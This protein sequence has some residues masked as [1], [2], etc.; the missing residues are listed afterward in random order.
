MFSKS[1][2]DRAFCQPIVWSQLSWVWSHHPPTQYWI[3]YSKNPIKNPSNN[4]KDPELAVAECIDPWLWDKVNS[5]IG[6]AVPARQ[7]YSTWLAVRYENLCRSWLYPTVRD[8]W[9]PLLVVLR[10]HLERILET[11]PCETRS[12]RLM[13]QGRTPWCASSTIRCRTTSGSGRPF[14]N[15]PP[16]WFTPP[17]PA[18]KR[19]RVNT[20]LITKTLKYFF[21]ILNSKILEQCS[22]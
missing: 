17:W 9:I 7:T 15:T 4:F 14:T 18:T 22:N 6:V 10:P 19:A 21:G 5:G 1:W 8:L 3:K 13:S 20:F 11:Q 16:S 12:W 2:V